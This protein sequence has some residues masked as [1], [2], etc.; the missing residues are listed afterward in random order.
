MGH[1]Q[2]TPLGPRRRGHQP[3]DVPRARL[4]SRQQAGLLVCNAQLLLEVQAFRRWPFGEIDVRTILYAVVQ[5]ST[6]SADVWRHCKPRSLMPDHQD[7]ESPKAWEKAAQ[8]A[9]ARRMEQMEST[10][11][12]NHRRKDTESLWRNWSRA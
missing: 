11:G 9:I 7:D 8:D 6:A 10:L 4:Q 1:G 5:K 3:P 12:G 2:H